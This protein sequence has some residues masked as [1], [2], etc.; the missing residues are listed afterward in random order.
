MDV[1]GTYKP[2]G[3]HGGGTKDVPVFYKG[4]IKNHKLEGQV[5]YKGKSGEYVGQ[6]G[7]GK[8]TGKGTFTFGEFVLEGIRYD[9]TEIICDQWKDDKPDGRH[10]ILQVLVSAKWKWIK[11]EQKPKTARSPHCIRS[12]L[13]HRYHTHPYQLC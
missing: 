12:T 3:E 6:L 4:D 2:S 5:Q 11:I 7:S 13:Q 10:N 9:G 1:S 8:K